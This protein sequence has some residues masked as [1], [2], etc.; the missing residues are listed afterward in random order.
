[1]PKKKKIGNK[2]QSSL[3]PSQNTTVVNNNIDSATSSQSSSLQPATTTTT[4]ATATTATTTT[5]LAPTSSISSVANTNTNQVLV[6][7]GNFSIPAIVYSAITAP[8]VQQIKLL[9]AEKTKLISEKDVITKKYQKTLEEN[10]EEIKNLKDKILILDKEIE[11]LKRENELM[12]QDMNIQKNNNILADL[13][14]KFQY[15]VLEEL[16]KNHAVPENTTYEALINMLK[17]EDKSTS[18]PL[19]EKCN[20]AVEKLGLPI[21]EW[22]NITKYKKMRNNVVH[23]ADYKIIPEARKIIDSNY[24]LDSNMLI[25]F[26]KLLEVVDKLESEDNSV[27]SDF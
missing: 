14:G 27:Y 23:L 22:K 5:V 4:T 17:R 12:I 18:K 16:I 13:A 3:H 25:S 9:E 11:K 10:Y 2:N 20:V 24:P 7:E 19:Q 21:K 15:Y 6:T 26:K 1:M 8:Y